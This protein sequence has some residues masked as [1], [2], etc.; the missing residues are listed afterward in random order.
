MGKSRDTPP[1]LLRLVCWD[2]LH[3]AAVLQDPDSSIRNRDIYT[4]ELRR[5]VACEPRAGRRASKQRHQPGLLVERQPGPLLHHQPPDLDPR[6]VAGCQ[7]AAHA[8]PTGSRPSMA[9]SRSASGC[10][11]SSSP[12]S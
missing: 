4:P 3:P 5:L 9:A 10:Q 1:I 8:L 6:P 11:P 2:A 7:F 12:T